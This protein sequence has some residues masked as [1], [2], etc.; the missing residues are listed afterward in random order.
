MTTTM[1]TRMKTTT[2]KP[3]CSPNWKRSKNSAGRGRR[4]ESI[5]ML[6]EAD[7]ELLGL[8]SRR[9]GLRVAARPGRV[10]YAWHT[11]PWPRPRAGTV[12]RRAGLTRR[13]RRAVCRGLAV[14][15][16]AQLSRAGQGPAAAGRSE[17]LRRVP[18][19]DGKRR[20]P[21]EA[22]QAGRSA[23]P[24]TWQRRGPSALNPARR[25]ARFGR[26]AGR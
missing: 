11:A 25:A 3:T 18:S 8:G 20:D 5:T 4:F 7:D 24:L 9:R 19:G 10:T 12:R 23:I 16:R 26:P 2:R 15:R 22:P 21:P 14:Y 13:L 17:P 1:T 6:K